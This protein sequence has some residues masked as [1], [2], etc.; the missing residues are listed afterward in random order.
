MG[1]IYRNEPIRWSHQAKDEKGRII[2]IE[3]HLLQISDLCLS[4][5]RIRRPGVPVTC[6][7]FPDGIP[8][9]V[10]AGDFDHVKE[11]PGDGGKQFAPIEEG[12]DPATLTRGGER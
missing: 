3:D 4:C 11:H 2:E 8:E 9:E 1:D 12:F 7:A 6:D 10:L 5:K